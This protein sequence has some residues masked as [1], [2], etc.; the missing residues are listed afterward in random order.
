MASNVFAILLFIALT[1]GFATAVRAAWRTG[2]GYIRWPGVIVG[3]LLSVI[4]L[5]VTGLSI[6][7]FSAVYSK[8]GRPVQTM[9]VDRTADRVARGQHIANVLCAS[10]HTT[11][12]QLPLTGGRNLAEDIHVPLGY[13]TP[14]NLTPSGPLKDWSDGEIF[15]AIREGADKDGNKLMVMSGQTAR[16]LGD[17][18]LKSVIAFLRSQ[19]AVPGEIRKDHLN[20]LGLVL[21][22]A[23]MVPT[24]DEPPPL[25][26]A[27]PA[28]GPTAEYGE[29]I[30]KWAGCR[31]CHG[32]ALN[33]TDGGL[34]PPG[35][36][37]RITKGWTG[38]QFIQTFRT[39]VDPF[40]KKLD[41][42]LMP[43]KF[44]GRMDDDELQAI[45]GYLQKLEIPLK[46]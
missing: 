44:V 15:R 27:T 43:W 19:P 20:P 14:Y 31:E 26:V 10:C 5:L 28:R 6:K 32:V 11:S 18:D 45:Y 29:Y 38:E 8:I 17:D 46:K 9:A 35:P 16:Y 42:L 25:T 22:G 1:L 34:L 30:V 7:G 33:G 12:T 4:A 41:P 36:S 23:K 21:V 2:K 40:G 13:L 24:I 3:G 39:G 37:L